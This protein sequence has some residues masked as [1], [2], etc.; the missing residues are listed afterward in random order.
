MKHLTLGAVGVCALTALISTRSPAQI[1]TQGQAQLPGGL[2]AGMTPDQLAQVLRQNPQLGNTVRQRLQQSGLTP[3]QIRAQLAAAGYPPNLLDAYLGA[4]QP[5]QPTPLP[6]AQIL[7]A[8]QALGLGTIT[9]VPESLHV[10]TGFI[11]V[12]AESLHA[13]SLSTGNYVF[14]VDVFR[15]TTTQF[16]PQLTGPVDPLYRLGPGDILVLVLTGGVEQTYQLEVTRE[17]FVLIPQA[18]QVYVNNLTLESA[19]TVFYD[20]LGRVYSKLRGPNPSIKFDVTVSRVRVNQ[21]YV[22]GEVKQ[23]GAYQMSALGSALTALYAAGGVTARANL[24]QIEIRRLDRVVATLDLYDYLLRGDKHNDIRLETADVVY[25]PLHGTRVQVT[26]AVLRPAIYELKEPETL[27]DLLRAAG[28]FRANAAADRLAIHRILPPAERRPGPLPR[29]ALDVALASASPTGPHGTAPP[30]QAPRGTPAEA[31]PLGGV[32]IPSLPLD[33]GDSVVVD[34]VGPLDSL[35]YVA[36]SGMVN[37]PGRYPWQ[38]GLTLRDLVKLARGP[39]IGASLKDVEIARLPADRRQGQLADTVRAP[40]DSTYLLERDRT[41]R[42]IGPAGQAFP[43]SG[44]LEVPLQ[45]YD[46]VLI[47]KQPDF[48]LQRTVQIRGE[49]RFP[50]T[51][52]LRSKSDRLTDVLDRAGGLTPQAYANGIRFYRR[53]ANAGRVGL[54]LPKVLENPT[55]RDNIV[56]ADG[57]SLYIPTYIPT[58]RVEGAVNSPG[59]V[60]YVRGEGLDYYLDAAGGVSFKGDKQ[61]V[62][63][64]QPNGNVRAVHKRPLFFGTSKPTPEPGAMVVVPVRD[65]INR[66]DVAS[67]LPVIGS[68]VTALTTILVVYLSRH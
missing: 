5:G 44:A 6:S 24:R 68:I 12:R 37:K 7:A 25:V 41:G 48:E 65:T 67:I 31:D 46:E 36:I 57:D 49:I 17:G 23:P 62:F 14:G 56:L 45:P 64:Q 52:A 58:V 39:K 4:G 43:G 33:N 59:S 13:E 16:L 26:G 42:Y 61:R 21:V 11:R 32:V 53:D 28:G 50:G 10:D 22:I 55:Y 66:S 30:G 40:I 63:V 15:R 35:L 51:Y 29:A 1:P 38:E 8:V 60:T 18:G 2:P 54:D 34:S 27:P 3:E 20:R 47:L 9:P 19:R